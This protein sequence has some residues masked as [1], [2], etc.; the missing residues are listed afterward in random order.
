MFLSLRPC[1]LTAEHGVQDTTRVL[2]I[3]RRLGD[4]MKRSVDA[5]EQGIVMAG[6]TRTVILSAARRGVD[7]VDV[8]EDWGGSLEVLRRA[9]SYV[10][11]AL[12]EQVWSEA[13]RRSNF[14]RIGLELANDIVPGLTGV[15][16]YMLR[17]C[18]DVRQ[19]CDIW[20][21][22]A[23][24][25]CD[26]LSGAI[27]LEGDEV[28][29]LWVLDWPMSLG[30]EHWS[31]YALARTVRLFREAT[32]DP[33]AAPLEVW[34]SHKAPINKSVHEQFFRA[35]VHFDRPF[36][37]LVWSIDWLEEK[38]LGGDLDSL[39]LLRHRASLL[40]AS[41]RE[42][43]SV[44]SRCLS[45]LNACLRETPLQL[46][47]SSVA[48]KLGYSPRTLQRYLSAEQTSFSQLLDQ[49]RQTYYRFYA[50][51]GEKTQLELAYLLGYADDAA[52]RKAI[53]RWQRQDEWF[54]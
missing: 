17:S 29:L 15:V 22:H 51:S 13:A 43:V 12:H 46:S 6:L 21:E 40:K 18:E 7:L 45:V 23:A 33:F 4:D 19:A 2:A 14:E 26:H 5:K 20:F 36:P 24:L 54:E 34:F 11:I 50:V 38:I 10:P 47:L 32:E 8:L 1:F 41:V 30:V 25:V 28:R 53:T 42:E 37:A 39:K 35:S 9:D 49:A 3:M 44:S 31:E 48:L 16:E 52:L 27:E